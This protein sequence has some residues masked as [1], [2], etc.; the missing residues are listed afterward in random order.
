MRKKNIM[1][2]KQNKNFTKL[3]QVNSVSSKNHFEL[4]PKHRTFLKPMQNFTLDDLQNHDETK[5]NIKSASN[6]QIEKNQT[7]ENSLPNEKLSYIKREHNYENLPHDQIKHVSYNNIIFPTEG[8][9]PKEY[10]NCF[11]VKSN[12]SQI[13]P[14]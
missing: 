1:N 10:F 7:P 14:N 4:A 11:D 12:S 13:P 5:E 3:F 8:L 9:S 2:M 6:L